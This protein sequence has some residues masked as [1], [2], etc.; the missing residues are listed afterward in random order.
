MTCCLAGPLKT[1]TWSL[2][3]MLRLMASIVA[4]R[5]SGQVVSRSPVLHRQGEG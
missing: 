3:A 5:L 1:L 2:W 4:K